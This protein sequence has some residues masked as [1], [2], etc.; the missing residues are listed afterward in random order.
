MELL[1]KRRQFTDSSTIGDLYVNG[2]FECY[3]LED[4]DRQLNS[5][6]DEEEILFHKIQD[7]TAIPYGRYEV[8]E[9]YSKR[10]QRVLPILIGVKGFA[11]IRIHPGNTP[12]QTHGCLLPGTTEG[13]NQILN[14]KLAFSRLNE[15]IAEALR[16]EK[17][18][19]EIVRA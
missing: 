6:M 3:V 15:Q 2:K 5:T 7:D 1:L 9:N 19:I 4:V 10:F 13:T 16:K 18:F 17:V 11:G 14:S 12:E 8:A